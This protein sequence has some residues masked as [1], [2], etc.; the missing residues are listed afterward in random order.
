[1]TGCVGDADGIPVISMGFD[2]VPFM[3]VLAIGANGKSDRNHDFYTIVHIFR[4]I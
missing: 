3:M 4:K 1:M 2:R